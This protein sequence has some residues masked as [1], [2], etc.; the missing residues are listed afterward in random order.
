[1]I[2]IRTDSETPIHRQI[3]DGMRLAISSG[4]F[5]AGDELPSVRGLAVQLRVNP[6][7][8]AKAYR[9]L[10]LLGVLE[11]RRGAG[12]FVAEGA[13][14]ATETARYELLRDRARALIDAGRQA[15]LDDESILDAV[16]NELQEGTA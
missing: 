1:V 16:R 15:G 12:T 7:T 2:E 13:D 14:R 9:E 6:N 5:R 8:V 11:K 3:V 10:E 4:R